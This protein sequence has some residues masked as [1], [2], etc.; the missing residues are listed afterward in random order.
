MCTCCSF[1]DVRARIR[2]QK[3]ENARI[4]KANQPQVWRDAAVDVAKSTQSS[5]LPGLQNSR[6][7]GD[8]HMGLA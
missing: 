3:V 4:V 6:Y 5:G 2:Q 8:P 1:L 7:P